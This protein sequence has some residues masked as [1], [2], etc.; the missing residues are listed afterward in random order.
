MATIQKDTYERVFS[1]DLMDYFRVGH[2][3]AERRFAQIKGYNGIC[4]H[5]IVRWHHVYNFE[6]ALNKGETK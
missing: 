3:Q 1:V 2:R 4:S 5:G 6:E